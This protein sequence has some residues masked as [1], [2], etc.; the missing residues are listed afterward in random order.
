[1]SERL[2]RITDGLAVNPAEVS[3]VTRAER[4]DV[5][6]ITMRDGARHEVHPAYGQAAYERF[7]GV[8]RMLLA[9][10]E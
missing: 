7:D 10:R 1:M 5:T 9:A 3:T 8:V 2:V 4:S 6:I